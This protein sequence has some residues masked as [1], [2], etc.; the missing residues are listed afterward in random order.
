[1]T[2]TIQITDITLASEA[3]SELPFNISNMGFSLMHNLPLESIDDLPVEHH[4]EGQPNSYLSSRE[5]E[6][7]CQCAPA[8]G[9]FYKRGHLSS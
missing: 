3:L 8:A 2:E 9:P 6:A 5:G 7:R 1:M 4:I